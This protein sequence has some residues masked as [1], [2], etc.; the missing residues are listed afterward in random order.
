MPP[1]RKKGGKGVK[2]KRRLNLGDLVLAKVKGFPAWPAKISKPEDWS[3]VP[4]PKKHFV[5]FFGTSE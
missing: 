4:D 1:T 3:K 2:E 5:Q